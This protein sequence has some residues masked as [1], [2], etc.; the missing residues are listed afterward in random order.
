MYVVAGRKC[1]LLEVEGICLR[2][3]RTCSRLALKDWT[4]RTDSSNASH[5]PIL[6][7]A[8]GVSRFPW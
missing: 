7:A 2:L 3:E 4:L 6:S 1:C 8:E 5:L